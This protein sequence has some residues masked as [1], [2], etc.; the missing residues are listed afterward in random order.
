MCTHLLKRGSRYS[1]RRKIP[2]SLIS[3]Y[4]RIEIIKSLRTSNRDEA[5]RFVRRE[6]C[7]PG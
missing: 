3:H 6:G 2:T 1:F 7:Y 4:Q 5:M